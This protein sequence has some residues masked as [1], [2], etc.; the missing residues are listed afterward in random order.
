M[1]ASCSAWDPSDDFLDH[2]PG[3][4]WMETPPKPED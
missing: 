4:D 2:P 3:C 1:V